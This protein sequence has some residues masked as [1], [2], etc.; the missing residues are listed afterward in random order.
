MSA[1]SKKLIDCRIQYHDRTLESLQIALWSMTN[2][3]SFSRKLQAVIRGT[4][5]KKKKT[6]KGATVSLA[7]AKKISMDS[8][9]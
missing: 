8:A 7:V 1:S 2:Q 4:R 9:V 6:G 3:L 5:G